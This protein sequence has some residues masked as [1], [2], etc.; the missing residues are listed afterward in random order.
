MNKELEEAVDYFRKRMDICLENAE[1]CDENDFDEEA[2]CL[3]KEQI[4][5]ETILNYIDNSTANKKI[6][7]L[8][9]EMRRNGSN[10]WANRLEEIVKEKEEGR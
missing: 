3:R 1:I 7:E 9:V 6:E 8:I 4:L 10:Y 5:I 2:I